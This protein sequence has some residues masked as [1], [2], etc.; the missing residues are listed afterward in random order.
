MGISSL[1]YINYVDYAINCVESDEIKL[2]DELD[3]LDFCLNCLNNVPVSDTADR[4]LLLGLV[5]RIGKRVAE[6][7]KKISGVFKANKTNRQKIEMIERKID[8]LSRRIEFPETSAEIRKKWKTA[9][10]KAKVIGR[11][12]AVNPSARLLKESYWVEALPI[13]IPAAFDQPEQ[14]VHLYKEKAHEYMSKWKTSYMDKMSF[15]EFMY[16]VIGPKLTLQERND[17]VVH[18][19]VYVDEAARINTAVAFIDGQATLKGKTI[20]PGEYMFVLDA[21]SEVLHIGKKIQNL[22]HHSSFERGGA[23]A[24]AGMITIGDQ[25]KILQAFPY[26]GHYRP[27]QAEM[28]ALRRYLEDKLGKTGTAKIEFV[29][30]GSVKDYLT[31]LGQLFAK[32]TRKR[33]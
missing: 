15:E 19:V 13:A 22:F 11:G 28:D 27:R 18:D 14:K 7:T 17:L 23:V 25:G 9:F 21:A 5:G 1:F 8:R 2:S 26:S 4:Q 24:S 29:S 6:D 10:D 3:I 31:T 12:S 30:Y 20:P 32:Y 33:Q 16:S